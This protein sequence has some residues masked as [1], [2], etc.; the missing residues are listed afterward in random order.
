MRSLEGQDDLLWKYIL[1]I[2][3]ESVHKLFKASLEVSTMMNILKVFNSG[4]ETWISE[5]SNFIQAFMLE[6]VKIDRFDTF[7]MFLEDEEKT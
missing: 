3:A 6:I 7:L 2:E 4:G 5:N 1:R